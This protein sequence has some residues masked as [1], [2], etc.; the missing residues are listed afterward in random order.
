M[1][2]IVF[3][4]SDTLRSEKEFYFSVQSLFMETRVRLKSQ[5]G[6]EKNMTFHTGKKTMDERENY[7]MI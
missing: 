4:T 7:E 1:V 3:S 6:N 5:K 2:K